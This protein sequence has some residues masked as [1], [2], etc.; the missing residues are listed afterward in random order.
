V[1]PNRRLA[2]GDR[3]TEGAQ[4]LQHLVGVRGDVGDP[5]G[6][7][8]P[9]RGVDQVGSA[10][11][12]VRRGFLR[13]ALGLVDLADRS[14]DVGEKAEREPLLFGESEV[15][16]RRVEGDADDVG[17]LSLELGGS[18]TEPLALDGSTGGEGL[19]EPPQHQPAIVEVREG[20]R[21]AALVRKREVR[22]ERPFSQ[23]EATLLV[24][25]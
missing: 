25:A 20:D 8:D 18:V 9:A 3:G 16:P 21:V 13:R 24:R 23:H 22:G 11:R 17:A 12:E 1:V 6:L 19:R 14:I 15:V 4:V 2:S 5:V 7:G 10:L